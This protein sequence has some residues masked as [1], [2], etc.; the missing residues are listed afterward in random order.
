MEEILITV[1][2]LVCVL[3]VVYLE[4]L[5][6]LTIYIKH[7]ECKMVAN[8]FTFILAIVLFILSLIGMYNLLF[9]Y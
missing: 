5:G 2:K 6:I 4:I 8:E 7:K 9:N 3:V 1:V